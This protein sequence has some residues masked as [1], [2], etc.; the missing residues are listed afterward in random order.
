V[1][2]FVREV[3]VKLEISL[4]I[5]K[6]WTFRVVDDAR[7]VSVLRKIKIPRIKTRVKAISLRAQEFWGVD[8][9]LVPPTRTWSA[10]PYL[11][12][13]GE[14]ISGNTTLALVQSS[15]EQGAVTLSD[16]FVPVAKLLFKQFQFELGETFFVSDNIII[17]RVFGRVPASFV[18]SHVWIWLLFQWIGS[19]CSHSYQ[20]LKPDFNSSRLLDM[21]WQDDRRTSDFIKDSAHLPELYQLWNG[22]I[23]EECDSNLA[24]P[25]ISESQMLLSLRIEGSLELLSLFTERSF[26]RFWLMFSVVI[27]ME[28]DQ[29]LRTLIH[30][31][32]RINSSWLWTWIIWRAATHLVYKSTE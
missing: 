4:A 23:R 27:F 12:T 13:V 8:S 15:K 29:Q 5:V 19:R 18:Y 31:S 14:A 20:F 3:I 6:F 24:I 7:P 22:E 11:S 26:L 9:A 25:H 17:D 1:I 30:A 32:I 10:F 2:I 28:Y 16:R 21:I